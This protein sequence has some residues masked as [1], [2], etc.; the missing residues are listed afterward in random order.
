MLA[1]GEQVVVGGLVEKE[2]VFARRLLELVHTDPVQVHLQLGVA[3]VVRY[4]K[5][6]GVKTTT[7]F[8]WCNK[9]FNFV[10]FLLVSVVKRNFATQNLFKQ[11]FN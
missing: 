1:A 7:L 9:K 4:S 3:I 10:F 11:P 5:A 6:G 2:M 8:F